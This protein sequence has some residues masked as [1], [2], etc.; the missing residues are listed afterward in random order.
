RTE[1]FSGDRRRTKNEEQQISDDKSN[2]GEPGNEEDCRW[3]QVRAEM[4]YPPADDRRNCK[5][6]RDDQDA[7]AICDRNDASKQDQR[8]Q[9]GYNELATFNFLDKRR[10]DEKQ[11]KREQKL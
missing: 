7:F 11:S 8:K 3:N 2:Q 5:H 1:H 4:I 6:D 9:A 10:R